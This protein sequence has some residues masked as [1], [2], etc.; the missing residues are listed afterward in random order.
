MK[1]LLVCRT[2][3][4][5]DFILSLPFIEAIKRNYPQVKLDVLISPVL[6]PLI[7]FVKGVDDYIIYDKIELKRSWKS[8]FSLSK[9][10]KRR[11]YDVAIALNPNLR[12]HFLLYLSGIPV[13]YGWAVKLGRLFLTD[14]LVHTKH[15]GIMHESQYNML[16]L[17]FIGINNWDRPRPKLFLPE[18]PTRFFDEVTIAIH[19]NASCPSKRWPKEKFLQLVRELIGRNFG[20][21]FI[22]DNFTWPIVSWILKQISDAEKK[23]V[24]N[25]VGSSLRDS[26]LAISGCDILVSNDSGPVHIASAL[27]VPSVVI[28]GRND[29]GLS[30]NRW[31]PLDPYSCYIHK[32]YCAN[33]LA[34]KCNNDFACLK[35][36]SVE[37][38]MQLVER[39]LVEVRLKRRLA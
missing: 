1:K 7:E 23:L 2:D 19:P 29:P 35:A 27:G 15:K 32:A 28:F 16:F 9:Q 13:R 22:G 17:P 6:E 14:S 18:P 5:G 31:K 34:H 39:V 20:I 8:F 11:N 37:E 21:V 38:V 26:V 36:I 25:L 30:P 24:K 4:I 3:R 10:L 33:C 12:L